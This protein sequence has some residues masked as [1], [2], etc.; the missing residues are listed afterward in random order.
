VG[1]NGLNRVIPFFCP[2]DGSTVAAISCSFCRV[3]FCENLIFRRRAARDQVRGRLP[4]AKRNLGR[5]DK[6]TV[7][8]GLRVTEQ[9]QGKLQTE[10]ED[11]HLGNP[12]M[13]KLLAEM[14]ST[15]LLTW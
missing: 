2:Q 7:I 11:M 8:F 12:V 4:D 10:I 13:R 9:Y 5:P 3:E 6:L 1:T 15:A 14:V